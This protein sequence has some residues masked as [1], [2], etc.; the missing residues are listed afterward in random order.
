M[1]PGTYKSDK[2][3]IN[4]GIEKVYLKCHC[5]DRSVVNGIPEPTLYSFALDKPAGHKVYTEP[6]IKLLKGKEISFIS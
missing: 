3:I 2:H 1:I 6:I 4:T 5:I